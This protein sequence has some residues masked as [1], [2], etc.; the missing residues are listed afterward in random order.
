MDSLK[1]TKG[2]RREPKMDAKSSKMDRPKKELPLRDSAAPKK[3]GNSASPTG[4]FSHSWT[5]KKEG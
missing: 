3:E 4:K 1:S 5:P 2:E